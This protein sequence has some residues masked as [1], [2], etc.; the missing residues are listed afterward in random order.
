M[1]AANGTEWHE[2]MMHQNSGTYEN[3]Y[4]VLDTNKVAPG[5]PLADGALTVG[6]QAPGIYVSVHL[7]FGR[8]IV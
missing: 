2:I 4:M 7:S 6:E 3:Q 5:T 8:K 1:L